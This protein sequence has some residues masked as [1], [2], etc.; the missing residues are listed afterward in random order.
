RSLLDSAA[1]MP[2][3]ILGVLVVVAAGLLISGIVHPL[4]VGACI[5]REGPPPTQPPPPAPAWWPWMILAG[6]VG[7]F[8]LG[9]GASHVRHRLE[10]AGLNSPAARRGSR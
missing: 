9:H 3:V 10:A 4:A 8:A 7:G 1:I 2:A 5:T 6:A